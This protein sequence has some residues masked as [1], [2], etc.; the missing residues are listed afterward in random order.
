MRLGLDPTDQ[1]L[2][3][4]KVS[5]DWTTLGRLVRLRAMK[6]VT[7]R[8]LSQAEGSLDTRPPAKSAGSAE[9]RP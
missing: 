3:D 2:S 4:S 8:F 1:R 5:P 9:G 6:D 7:L